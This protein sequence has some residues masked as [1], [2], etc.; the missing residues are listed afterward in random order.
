MALISLNVVS[1]GNIAHLPTTSTDT[2]QHCAAPQTNADARYWLPGPPPRR[3]I[4]ELR[5]PENLPC[6]KHHLKIPVRKVNLWSFQNRTSTTLAPYFDARKATSSL[7]GNTLSTTQRYLFHGCANEISPALLESFSRYGPS[8]YFSRPQSYFSRTPAVYWTESLDFAFAWCLSPETTPFECLIYVSRVEQNIL[9]DESHC[10]M[11]PTPSNYDEEQQLVEWCDSNMSKSAEPDRVPPPYS[12][13]S[14]WPLIGSRIPQHTMD[15]LASF[16]VR[17]FPALG[18]TRV[19]DIVMYAA[20][21]EK[22]SY[23]LASA[24]VEVRPKPTKSPLIR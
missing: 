2:V 14:D 11:V 20:C 17:E 13:R 19:Q 21:D 15:S 1:K 23:R 6:I 7:D 12:N 24:G 16:N 10:Y 5:P 9:I 8:I 18:T 22:M 3:R 4:K